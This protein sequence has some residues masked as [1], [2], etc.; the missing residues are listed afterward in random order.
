MGKLSGLFDKVE[1]AYDDVEA[2]R[3]VVEETSAAYNA[4]AQDLEKAEQ[5]L[6]ELR[7]ET[8]KMLGGQESNSRA[9]VRS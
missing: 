3:L 4:A 7:E 1:K 5:Q 8:N 2:K 9:V 6:R